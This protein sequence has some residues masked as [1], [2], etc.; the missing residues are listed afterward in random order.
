MFKKN[1]TYLI[2]EIGWNF[3]GNLSLAKKMIDEAK[4]SGADFVKFQIWNPKNLKKGEWDNDGRKEIYKKAFLD[5]QKF[6][7]LF[8]YSKKKKI[9]CFASIFSKTELEDYLSVTKDFIKIPSHEAYNLDLIKECIKRFKFVF[10]S[11]GCLTYV[12]LKKITKFSRFS[13]VILM[14]CVSS[15]PLISKNCNFKKFD[16]LKKFSNKVGYS[17]HYQG[18]DDALFAIE[19]NASIIEKHFTINNKLPG[20]DNRFALLP[21]DFKFLSNYIQNKKDFQIDKGLN[22]QKCEKDIYKNYRGRWQ[23]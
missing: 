16:Y 23:K 18:I 5:K 13:N 22:V 6:K 3:L 19:K 4:V 20:R 8:D 9:K 1:H 14:H 7:I 2:A 17:G 11:C 15:Y 21:K 10:I 12:E